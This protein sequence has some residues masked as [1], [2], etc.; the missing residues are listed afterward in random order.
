[1]ETGWSA[2]IA[3]CSTPLLAFADGW[4]GLLGTSRWLDATWISGN[5][6]LLREKGWSGW[7]ES[8]PHYQLGKLK[9]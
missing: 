2:V 7:R 6:L 1:M 9:F 8:N 5:Y 3:P 4:L